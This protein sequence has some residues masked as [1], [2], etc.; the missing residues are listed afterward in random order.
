MAE[1]RRKHEKEREVLL[2]EAQKLEQKE[3]E[4]QQK[5]DEETKKANEIAPENN[6]VQQIVSAPGFIDAQIDKWRESYFVETK[7]LKHEEAEALKHLDH[8]KVEFKEA[9]ARTVNL[10]NQLKES[11]IKYEE[12]LEK[13]R[14]K[15]GEEL[16]ELRLIVEEKEKEIFELEKQFDENEQEVRKRIQMI[17][18]AE[19]KLT[20]LRTKLAE[21]KSKIKEVIKKEYQPLINQEQRRSEVMVSELEKLRNE[22]ELSVE[23]LKH[24]LLGIET[25]NAAMEE[26]LK[27]ETEKIIQDLQN[28]LRQKY[29]KI[30]EEFI[31]KM[32][33]IEIDKQN[34]VNDE[35][36]K[37]EDEVNEIKI[38]KENFIQKDQE[39]YKEKIEVLNNECIEILTLN[40]EKQELIR[41]LK[42]KK[43]D[44]CPILDKNLKKLE[45]AIVKM[46]IQDRDLALDGQNKRDMIHKLGNPNANPNSKP[47]K[48][49]MLPSKP[50]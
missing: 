14:A 44:M 3:K 48:L 8:C 40:S 16:E 26:D 24:D 23:Y 49:P 37:L 13:A 29:E 32:T 46:Q 11:T 5:L 9:V 47:A 19:D 7:N 15:G 17:D 43:C 20:K 4:L 39:Q 22:L 33:Q 12:A 45:K 18:E 28:E 27:S 1:L 42:E 30:E 36:A 50:K 21:E 41:Q 10:R 25:S 34:Q 6:P 35:I 2:T 31:S 38:E